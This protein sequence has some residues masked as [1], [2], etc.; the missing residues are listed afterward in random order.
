[1]PSAMATIMSTVLAGRPPPRRRRF[2]AAHPD[3]YVGD[4]NA[5]RLAIHGG[6]LLT[7]SLAAPGFASGVHP[8]WAALSPLQQPK[9]NILQE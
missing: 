8:L 9:A 2:A 7:G 5:V 3:L 4:G 1:M 6:D